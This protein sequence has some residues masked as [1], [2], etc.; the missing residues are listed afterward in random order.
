M[1]LTFAFGQIGISRYADA[2]I[3]G[4]TT[5]NIPT[6]DIS[7]GEYEQG[8]LLRNRNAYT[9]GTTGFDTGFVRFDGLEATILRLQTYPVDI[10]GGIVGDPDNTL[11]YVY[12][13]Y[14]RGYSVNA[15][16][17]GTI[18]AFDGTTLTITP[19]HSS[20]FDDGV[21]GTN[22]KLI[23]V[24][25]AGSSDIE[26]MLYEKKVSTALTI[27]NRALY[28]GLGYGFTNLDTVYVLDTPLQIV[29]Q[30]L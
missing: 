11:F 7:D 9:N 23:A 19:A 24:Q 15:S 3:D 26:F 10:T 16:A 12:D 29:L 21:S 8:S 22:K 1:N 27:S 20:K 5:G 28:T 30:D 14:G 13:I 2:L 17:T 6:T 4:G 18:S 25:K